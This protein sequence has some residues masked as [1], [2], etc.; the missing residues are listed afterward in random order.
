[1]TESL[2]HLLI[3]DVI[4]F[5]VYLIINRYTIAKRGQSIGKL[6]MRIKIVG[7]DR[8]QATFYR[9]VVLRFPRLLHT[10]NQR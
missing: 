7:D 3:L 1:M 4:A 9:I 10:Q 8:N 6:L 5:G 2:F